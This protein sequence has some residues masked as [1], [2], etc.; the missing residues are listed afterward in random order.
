MKSHWGFLERQF[1]RMHSSHL[2]LLNLYLRDFFVI[3]TK[4]R[5]LYS[6]LID[7]Q[8]HCPAPGVWGEE[9]ERIWWATVAVPAGSHSLG[10]ILGTS[11]GGSAPAAPG[12]RAEQRDPGTARPGSG[13]SGCGCD[14]FVTA[15][16]LAAPELHSALLS[17]L[18]LMTAGQLT[19]EMTPFFSQVKNFQFCDR[20]S[21]L[22]LRNLK[23]K[24]KKKKN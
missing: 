11:R 17:A 19:W 15:S 16:S 1:L 22:K 23:L 6:L 9:E 21:E 2:H 14:P 3:I 13:A 8:N 12:G 10:Q 20:S 18:C 4:A 7:C 5:R 24:K